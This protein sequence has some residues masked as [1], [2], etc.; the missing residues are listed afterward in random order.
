MGQSH[1]ERGPTLVPLDPVSTCP[2]ARD[3]SRAYLHHLVRSR[4]YLGA[5]LLSW[6]NT[7]FYQQLMSAMRDAI[8]QG[9]FAVWA[10][11]TKK[12]L[13]GNGD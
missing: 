7:A 13:T 3:Y 8:S 12:R 5:M 2:A 4:E 11:E 1:L 9:R 10:A 6:S